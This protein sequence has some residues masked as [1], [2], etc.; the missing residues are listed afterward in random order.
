MD[1]NL[2]GVTL[3][4]IVLITQMKNSPTPGE[5]CIVNSLPLGKPKVVN[6]PPYPGGPSGFDLIAPIT[7]LGFGL[8]WFVIFNDW[9]N[10][11]NFSH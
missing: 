1:K 2:W 11:F 5:S 9:F 3:A 10:F 6:L 8:L 7:I 4:W